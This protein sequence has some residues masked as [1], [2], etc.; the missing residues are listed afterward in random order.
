MRNREKHSRLV[1]VAA[2]GYGE[3]GQGGGKKG[4]AE[5]KKLAQCFRLYVKALFSRILGVKVW[6]GSGVRGMVN[7]V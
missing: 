6:I 7:T 5:T 4:R 1:L 3:G 2:K